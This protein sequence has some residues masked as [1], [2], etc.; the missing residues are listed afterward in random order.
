MV[1]PATRAI[2]EARAARNSLAT[3]YRGAEWHRSSMTVGDVTT[4]FWYDGDNVVADLDNATPSQSIIKFY[5]TPFLDQNLVLITDGETY[6]YA[7]SQTIW[8]HLSQN[9]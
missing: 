8:T 2:D 3:K 6:A 9:T 7:R 4:N 1:A 5:V